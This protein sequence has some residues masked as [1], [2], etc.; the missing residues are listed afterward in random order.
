VKSGHSVII[1]PRNPIAIDLVIVKEKIFLEKICKY[2]SMI[3]V[4]MLYKM[5][6]PIKNAWIT[7]IA[8]LTMNSGSEINPGHCGIN[9]GRCGINSGCRGI[10]S[11][12]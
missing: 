9:P 1:F 12:H 10:C 11:Y 7:P 8:K 4:Q 3:L 5:F 2:F 6:L